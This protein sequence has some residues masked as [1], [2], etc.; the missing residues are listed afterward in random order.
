M[1]ELDDT[2]LTVEVKYTIN[3]I[4]S[5][6]KILFNLHYNENFN[7]VKI[8]QFK[9]KYSKIKPYLLRLDNISKDF[10][11]DNRSKT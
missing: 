3:F 10:T 6:K 5:K 7:G 9:A 2:G 1:Q 4:E 8:Y 11:A